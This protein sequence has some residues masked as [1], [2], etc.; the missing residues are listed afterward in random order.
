MSN[1]K[2]QNKYRIASTRAQ[3][4]DYSGNGAY[5]ITICT[6]H[7]EHLFGEIVGGKMKLSNIGVIADMLWYE[8]KNHFDI[9]ELGEFVVMPNHVHGIVI[10][11]S[12]VNGPIAD[13]VETLHA[14][15]LPSPSSPPPPQTNQFMQFISPKSKSLAAVVRSYK[16]AVTNHAHRLGYNFAWQRNYYERI[17][18]DEQAYQN[19]SGYIANNPLMWPEDEFY[20]D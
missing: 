7:R 4:W 5:F 1:G 19:I 8:I 3:W 17:V 16:S 13:G 20:V 11:N 2:F 12:P 9:V 18:R 6:A 10:I 15:S 14:T